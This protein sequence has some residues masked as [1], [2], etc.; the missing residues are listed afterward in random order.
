MPN[1]FL[2]SAAGDDDQ[3]V[4]QFFDDLRGR[5]SAS[6]SD[7]GAGFSFLGTVGNRD[8]ALPADMLLRLASCDVFVALTS[9]RYFRTEAC[10]RQWQIF[11]DRFPA[12]ARRSAMIAVAWAAGAVAPGFAGEVMTPPSEEAGRGLRQLIRLHSLRPAYED[13]VDRLAAR[14]VAVGET[15]PA[16]TAEQVSDF[17]A[18]PSAFG[19]STSD[20]RVH[21]VVAAASREEMENV[22]TSLAYYGAEAVDW[23]PYL[24]TVPESLAGRA[25]LLAADQSLSPEVTALDD[26][27]A[28]LEQARAANE[29]VVILCDWWLTQLDVYKQLLAEIDSRGLDTV[30]ILVPASKV[31]A[32]TMANLPELRFGFRATFR[33]STGRA[34]SLVRTDIASP[35]SFDADLVDILEEARNRL[36]R[37]GP[38]RHSPVGEPMADRP[39]LQGP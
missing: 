12:G 21:L 14:I 13:F 24:P 1:F 7:H 9:P 23:A 8:N 31:D 37:V 30:A 38:Q 33:R 18:V 26:V 28:R 6:S 32:E 15:S 39:I 27:V 4:R 2:S 3:Y 34:H 17:T 5:V 10:G 16:P 19:P 11:A 22:R 35:D 20:P 29:I 36:F 25:R